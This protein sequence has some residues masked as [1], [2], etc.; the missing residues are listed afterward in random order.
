GLEWRGGAG[1]RGG[2]EGG[3]GPG[4]AAGAAAG[5]GP[6]GGGEGPAPAGAHP[7]TAE[8]AVAAWPLRRNLRAP[9]PGARPRR[10]TSRSGACRALLLRLG[11]RVHAGQSRAGRAE[12]A[13]RDRRG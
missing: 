13:S 11:A 1:G 12:C 9:A 8:R 3:G 2:G 5:G 7:P 4:G 10:A 6:P